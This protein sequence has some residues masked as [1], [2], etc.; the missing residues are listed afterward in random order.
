[1]T[2]SIGSDFE[3][4]CRQNFSVGHTFVPRA[5]DV[6]MMKVRWFRDKDRPDIKNVRL[7][8]VAN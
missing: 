8:N 3:G 2:R 1:M 7:C 4:A 6:I 5:E